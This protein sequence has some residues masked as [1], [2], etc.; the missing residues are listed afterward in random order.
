MDIQSWWLAPLVHARYAF[1]MH[2]FFDSLWRAIAY[3]LRPAILLMA[4][5]PLIF[6][7]ALTV[8]LGYLFWDS[9]MDQVLHLMESS[10]F[11][12]TAWQ[13]LENMGVGQLKAVM[14][15]LLVI[16]G[17]TP[18]IVITSLL[19]VALVMSPMM[20]R[21]VARRRFP[22]L[23]SAGQSSLLGGLAWSLGSTAMALLALVLSSPLWLIPPLIL[24]VPPLIWGWLTYRV[25]TFDA[26]SQH[27]TVQERQ[28]IFRRHRTGL[29]VMGVVT[30][31]ISMAPSLVWGS[32]VVFAAAFVILVPL[33]VLIYTMVF[34]FSSLWFTHYGLSALARLRAE[35]STAA[36]TP[37]ADIL[38]SP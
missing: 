16:F 22:A 15:P 7:I 34:A 26:L 28:E 21:L 19:A 12:K 36:S 8:G 6:M 31:Y 2:L 38:E 30:G 23:Q 35:P 20:V 32:G 4:L 9:A 11:M 18:F 1:A 17:V 24:I 25:M 10:V 5:V 33:A 3:C 37:Y 29:L 14:A 27:A 13:W